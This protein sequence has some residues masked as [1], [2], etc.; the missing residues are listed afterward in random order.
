MLIEI[1]IKFAVGCALGFVAIA[2]V[3]RHRVQFLWGPVVGGLMFAFASPEWQAVAG[4]RYSR[5]S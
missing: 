2:A 3:Y 4:R 1:V 5:G